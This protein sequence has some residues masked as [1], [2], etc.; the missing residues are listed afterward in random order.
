MLCF[1]P[2]KPFMGGLILTS[3]LYALFGILEQRL[4]NRVYLDSLVE[5]AVTVMIILV[6]GFLTT[7]WTG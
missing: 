6:V 5:Y 3:G 2:V 4:S 7:T 1:W